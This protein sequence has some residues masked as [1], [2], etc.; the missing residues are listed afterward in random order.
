MQTPVG[1]ANSGQEKAHSAV[2]WQC[3]I[4]IKHEHSQKNSL[5]RA[6]AFHEQ[7]QQIG[8]YRIVEQVHGLTLNQAVE[9]MRGP[10]STKIKLTIM[11]EGSESASEIIAGAL[12]DHKRATLLGTR[13][14]GEGSVRTII[15]LRAGNGALRLT[16]GALLHAV[17]PF[18]PGE[19]HHAR[20]KDTSGSAR[21]FES[22]DR[23]HGG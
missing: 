14:F 11:R 5:L 10:V 9:K 13:S 23:Q 16:N 1:T 3:G 18:H 20:H 7:V 12:Q 8:L 19:G 2:C 15:P 21:R 22:A 17:R 4:V 6:Q